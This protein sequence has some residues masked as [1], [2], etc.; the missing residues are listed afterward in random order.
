MEAEVP[1]EV[2]ETF[3]T[4]LSNLK[5]DNDPIIVDRRDQITK[6]LNTEFRSTESLIANRLMVGSYGRYTAIRGVSDIDLLYIL[7]SSLEG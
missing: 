1:V 2:S 4:L 6:A 3:E 5:L 7:P